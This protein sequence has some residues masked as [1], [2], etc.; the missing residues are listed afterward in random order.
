MKK[1]E[2]L[3]EIFEHLEAYESQTPKASLEGFTIYLNKK[4]G[5]IPKPEMAFDTF[6]DKT[7]NEMSQRGFGLE[8]HI[9]YLIGMM[10]KYAKHY[11]KEGFKTLPIGT[12]DDFSFLASL[13]EVDSMTKTELITYNILEIPSG[14]EVIKRLIKLGFV[15]S[16]AD[17]ND[18][19]AKRL[20]I[21]PDGKKM[22]FA[23]IGQ[24]SQIAK[25]IIGDLEKRD[26]IS[27]LSTLEQ[28]NQFHIEI[29][30][31]DW[32]SGLETITEKYVQV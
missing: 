21:T 3:K 6:E 2:L 20:K 1:Y 9:T 12:I 30:K 22:L 17:P 4:Q 24:L 13:S 31:N 27:L 7:L 26:Q 11:V 25:I 18:K 8:N 29:H 10:W 5:L 15:E 16:F 23:A 32:K 28:L 14:M 19:R